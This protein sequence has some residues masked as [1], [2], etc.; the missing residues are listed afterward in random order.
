MISKKTSEQQN[1]PNVK[2]EVLPQKTMQTHVNSVSKIET[3]SRPAKNELV[4][5]GPIIKKEKSTILNEH[6]TQ[7][8]PT[9]TLNGK[10]NCAI[11]IS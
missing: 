4:S 2:P 5:N 11:Y 9:P 7:E 8:K 10:F 3:T 1:K 6:A